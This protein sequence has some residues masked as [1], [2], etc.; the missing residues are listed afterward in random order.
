MSHGTC[1][2]CLCSYIYPNA[3]GRYNVATSSGSPR[4]E[5]WYEVLRTIIFPCLPLAKPV[6]PKSNTLI[7]A[8]FRFI[9]ILPPPPCV[10]RQPKSLG[11]PYTPPT[12]LS[13]TPSVSTSSDASRRSSFNSS[14]TTQSRPALPRSTSYLTK[15]RRST[16]APTVTVV[17]PP[18]YGSTPDTALFGI[19]SNLKDM[20]PTHM[21]AVQKSTPQ[22]V[23]SQAMPPEA[24][25]SP[26]ESS[27][28]DESVVELQDRAREIKNIKE[29][30]EAVSV[31]PQCRGS[32]PDRASTSNLLLLPPTVGRHMKSTIDTTGLGISHSR[33]RTDTDIYVPAAS[34]VLL[35]TSE[36]NSE[37][38]ETVKKPPMVRK[39]SGELVRPALRPASLRRPSSMPGTPTFTKAV[40]FDSHLE[41]VR[42]FLQVDKP[43]AV[44]TGPL[45][46]DNYDSDAEDPFKSVNK[47]GHRLSSHE[48]EIMTNNFPAETPIRKCL[49]VRLERVWMSPDQKSLMGSVSVANLAFQKSVVCRFTFDYWKTTSEIGA[50][51]QQEIRQRDTGIGHDRFQFSIKLSDIANLGAKTLFLCIRY[52]VNGL[53]YWDNN[54]KANFQV[55]FHTKPQPQNVKRGLHGTFSSSAI[56]L[57]RSSRQAHPSVT[58]RPRSAPTGASGEFGQSSNLTNIDQ[59]IHEFLD[60]TE[61]NGLRL[62]SSKSTTN[63]STGNLPSR[64]STSGGTAF[65]NRYDFGA[66]L[67]AAKQAKKSPTSSPQQ[68]EGLYMKPHQRHPLNSSGPSN[69]VRLQGNATQVKSPADQQLDGPSD[70]IVPTSGHGPASASST[71]ISSASYEEILNKY[72]FFNSSKQSSPQSNCDLQ[73]NGRG[74]DVDGGSTPRSMSAD[75]GLGYDFTWIRP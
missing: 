71:S 63:I 23:N 40:H 29:L 1:H 14:T 15:H 65:A 47:A 52:N 11:M 32:S 33:S 74:D 60:K 2:C 42:H 24:V 59:P 54:D 27:S 4:A 66:S 25:I 35:G 53:E 48:W 46:A 12:H 73:R 69:V 22:N 45:P 44:S 51:Y 38:D 19:S 62:K 68:D 31:I 56:S 20:A 43:L 18:G 50:E 26:P 61:P 39:K 9:S 67:S 75:P 17:S 70:C 30:K 34:D 21:F 6:V 55:D 64:L 8:D 49:P 37:Q 13:P 28:E 3:I 58:G 7:F 36:D 10:V 41:H 16:S 5:P 72:C 57:P